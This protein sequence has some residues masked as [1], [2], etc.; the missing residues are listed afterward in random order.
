MQ[1][2]AAAS[3]TITVKNVLQIEGQELLPVEFTV[4]STSTSAGQWQGLIFT[5]GSAPFVAVE[6]GQARGSLVQHAVIRYTGRSSSPAIRID[7]SPP[8]LSDIELDT[9][10]TVGL[11]ISATVET[12]TAT[13]LHVTNAQNY[14]VR[15]YNG[16]KCRPEPCVIEDSTIRATS[17]GVYID[18]LPNNGILNIR[19]SRFELQGV[20]QYSTSGA[21]VNVTDS[22]FDGL[23]SGQHGVYA[24]S[25]PVDVNNCTFTNY[26]SWGINAYQRSGFATTVVN[27]RFFDT[28]HGLYV[29]ARS[30]RNFPLTVQGNLFEGISTRP[31]EISVSA[32]AT[33][34][35]VI[36]DNH[37]T[38]CSALS[39]IDDVSTTTSRQ[40]IIANNRF[41]QTSGSENSHV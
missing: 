38:R 12:F 17:A 7:G 36:E 22:A 24:S 4:N 27:S 37:V 29:Y 35:A 11:A 2:Y 39:L 19:G 14:G 31:F 30:G 3:T 18:A 21:V 28:S 23:S 8:L 15:I 6:S 32:T 34:S 16:V 20:W 1:V 40:L 5:T 9:V 33:Q 13:R 41:E 10:G 26:R 25:S